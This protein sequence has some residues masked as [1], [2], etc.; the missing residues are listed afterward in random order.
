MISI[1]RPT[2]PRAPF[3]AELAA[4][5]EAG[6]VGTGTPAVGE[7]AVVV[8]PEYLRA[9]PRVV[10]AA[11]AARDWRGTPVAVAA[12]GGRDRGRRA[13]ED[14]REVLTAAGARPT[15]VSLGIDVSAVRRHGFDEADVVLRDLVLD[16]LRS[17]RRPARSRPRG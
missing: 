17:G 7:A 5:L 16:E 15:P 4:W 3:A 8:V 1:V 11:L 14:T 6:I 9:A 12:Y 2:M 13:V 10:L